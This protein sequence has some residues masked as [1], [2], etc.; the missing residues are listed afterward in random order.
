[1]CGLVRVRGS[2]TDTSD[3]EL[4]HQRCHIEVLP[5]L[6]R[7]CKRIVSCVAMASVPATYIGENADAAQELTG[8]T[9]R[10]VQQ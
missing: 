8:D 9:I 7:L 6:C 2:G 3:P 5:D 10:R 1:M 4:R